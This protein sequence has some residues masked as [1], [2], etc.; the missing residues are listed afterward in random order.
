MFYFR[1]QTTKKHL[2]CLKEVPINTEQNT[3]LLPEHDYA[4]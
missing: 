1:N 3:F 4:F 2:F